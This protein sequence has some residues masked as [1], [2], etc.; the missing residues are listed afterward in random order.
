MPFV[1]DSEQPEEDFRANKQYRIKG[2]SIKL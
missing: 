2:A 1:E